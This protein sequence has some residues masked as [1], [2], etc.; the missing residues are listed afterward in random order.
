MDLL[1]KKISK[2]TSPAKIND[3][4]RKLG[5]TQVQEVKARE[6]LKVTGSLEKNEKVYPQAIAVLDFPYIQ[7]AL[8]TCLT[9]VLYSSSAAA[10]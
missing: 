10:G 7:S 6:A 9:T 8:L 1:F 4:S 5:N 3:V 2:D